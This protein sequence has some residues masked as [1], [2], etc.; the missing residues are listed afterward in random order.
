MVRRV[1]ADVIRDASTNVGFFY[2]SSSSV[3]AAARNSLRD[4]VPPATLQFGITEFLRKQF[5]PYWMPENNSFRCPLLTRWRLVR[6][7]Y[8][9]ALLSG[10]LNLEKLDIHKSSNFKGYTAL[11][12]ENTNPENQGDLHEGF[13]IGWESEF[14][15]A[16]STAD[17]SGDNSMSGKNVWPD[18]STL[19]GFRKAVLAY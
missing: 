3:F 11:L 15:C 2:S 10:Q 6:F 8:Y 14:P 7:P 4:L 9:E 16:S 17:A 13:D 5:R 12:G 18:A 1:L 19:P